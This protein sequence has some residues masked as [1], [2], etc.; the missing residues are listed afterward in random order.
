MAFEDIGQLQRRIF[1][2]DV[3]QLYMFWKLYNLQMKCKFDTLIIACTHHVRN[4]IQILTKP[5]VAFNLLRN[6]R[7]LKNKVEVDGLL[8]AQGTRRPNGKIKWSCQGGHPTKKS[9]TWRLLV[10]HRP[11]RIMPI[12]K[13]M[14]F[15]PSTFKRPH[16]TFPMRGGLRKPPRLFMPNRL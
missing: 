15:F 9:H 1:S 7:S 4:K 14:T 12:S 8:S 10:F 6:F 2:T 11:I 16:S 13:D 5:P 3:F